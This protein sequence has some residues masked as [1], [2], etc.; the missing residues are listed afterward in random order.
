MN[1]TMMIRNP[2]TNEWESVYLPPGGDTYPIGA[3]AF[4]AGEKAPTGWLR[5]DGQAV[6]R[7][8][9]ADLFNVIGTTYGAGDGST[10]FNL[11]N[12][13]LANRT[14]VGSSGDGE[15][16]LG[17]TTG[18][19][20]HTLTV[21]ELPKHKPSIL[22]N[23]NDSNITGSAVNYQATSK[24]RFY[25]ADMFQNIGGG[26]SHNNMQPSIAAICIIKAKQSIGLVGSVT[27]DINDQNDNAVVNA[28]T[29]KEHIK[30]EVI[31]G[32]EIVK[33]GYKIDGKDVYMKRLKT[34]FSGSG[35]MTIPCNM[36]KL[37]Y[38]PLDYNVLI[39]NGT[40]LFK[41]NTPRSQGNEYVATSQLYA[42]WQYGTDYVVLNSNG[43]DRNGS[44]VTIDLYFVYNE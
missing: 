9:Y 40:V 14:L 12:V 22:L 1:D 31:T 42:F 16:A 6:S 38:T 11:P 15:F 26:A 20:E 3:Y 29:V 37:N 21:D 7:T 43:Q 18:E 13:N 35:N 4:I 27:K 28:K 34:T 5:A 17:N 33:C 39:D 10:T 36:S 23:T 32:G 8:E 24:G 2:E 25:S 44:I 41:G 19:K 30:E